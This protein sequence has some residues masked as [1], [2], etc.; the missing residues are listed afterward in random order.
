MRPVKPRPSWDQYFLK[1]AML[2]AER[3]TCR[4]H[5]VGAVIV[6]DKRIMTT[7]YNGA[8]SGVKDSIELGCLRDQLDIPSGTMQEI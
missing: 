7:G 8:P 1:I 2:V 4:R 5:H 6:K 3:A